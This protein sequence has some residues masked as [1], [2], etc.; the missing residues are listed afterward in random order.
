MMITLVFTS[1]MDLV[2]GLYKQRYTPIWTERELMGLENL[3]RSFMLL[4]VSALRSY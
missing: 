4:V 3:I 1:Y 2:N